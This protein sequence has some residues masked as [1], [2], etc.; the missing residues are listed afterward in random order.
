MKVYTATFAASALSGFA[1]VVS[2]IAVF[3]ICA[4]VQN[5]WEEFDVEI[6]RFRVATDDLWTDMM[7]LNE[8]RRFRRQTYDVKAEVTVDN[9][10]GTPA[11]AENPYAPNP[12]RGVNSNPSSP[13]VPIAGPPSIPPT[14]SGEGSF[15]GPG[16]SCRADNK[17]PAGPPGP[18]GK[19]GCHGPDGIPGQDGK[20][21]VSG[22]DVT[23]E[24][25]QHGCF[26]CPTGP[27]GP[28]GAI[29][30]PGHRGM[31]GS[32]GQDGMPGRDGQPGFS[33]EMGPPGPPGPLGPHGPAGEK[34][35][36]A[37][38]P[39]GRPGPKGPRGAV[40]EQGLPGDDGIPAEQG[41][42]GPVGPEG[43]TGPQGPQGPIG[44][45]G[46]EGPGGRPGKDAEYC[47]CPTR[48]DAGV[49]SGYR[50]RH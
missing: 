44:E 48:A 28:P 33:G 27:Q 21:G 50:R 32:R 34:G 39:I 9:G 2:L 38:Q 23:P 8:K 26:N 49:R 10:Y 37:E 40:G 45:T 24:R 5:I 43:L 14:L 30:R 17:C 11:P 16:C 35:R 22:K 25:D 13:G 18:K 6:D 19:P 12:S 7:K 3:H 29:G 20:P 36:D 15:G 47:P 4:D 31:A 1:L 41:A 42:P 46:E